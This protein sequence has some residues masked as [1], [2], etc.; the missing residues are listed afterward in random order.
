MHDHLLA[1]LVAL[2][3][4]RGRAAGKPTRTG[5]RHAQ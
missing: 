3:K 2:K 5:S 4:L 1:Q